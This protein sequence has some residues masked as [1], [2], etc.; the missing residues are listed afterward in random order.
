ME[1]IKTT[2][3]NQ[4]MFTMMRVTPV[5]LRSIKRALMLLHEDLNIDL[6]SHA[7]EILHVKRRKERLL[8]EKIIKN[9]PS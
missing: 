3:N 6:D 7:D 4:D 8:C 9:I 1:I 2:I 5:E